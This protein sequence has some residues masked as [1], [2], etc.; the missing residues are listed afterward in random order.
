MEEELEVEQLW[1]RGDL[2][3]SVCVVIRCGLDVFYK[4]ALKLEETQAEIWL[5]SLFWL[6][7]SLVFN[8]AV[9]GKEKRQ[10]FYVM[11]WKSG[12]SWATLQQNV[13]RSIHKNASSVASQ[14]S[15]ITAGVDVPLL[16]FPALIFILNDLLLYC[17]FPQL[18]ILQSACVPLMS[19]V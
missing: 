2:V 16:L 19:F 15:A 4:S 7:A 12:E 14:Y 5:C 18:F 11:M 10:L 6:G 8:S 1:V 3:N 9:K 13:Q 17:F